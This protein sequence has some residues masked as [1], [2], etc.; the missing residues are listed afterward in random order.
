MDTEQW[1]RIVSSLDYAFQPIVSIHTG[2]SLGYEA[3]LRN[4]NNEGFSGIQE[5][6]DGA[7]EDGMLFQVELWLR[8]KAIRKFT[9]I[10]GHQSMKLFFNIDNRVL[11][12]PDY[13]PGHTSRLLQR[14]GLLPESLCFE[15]SERHELD[16]L[17]N[18][19]NILSIYRQQ[20]YKIAIDD[21]GA[22]YSGLRLLYHSEPDFIKID[23]FFI[24]G[25]E[26]DSKK[27]LFVGK[28]LNLAHILG[29]IVIA[30]GVETEKEYYICK[31]IGC[32][33]IQGYLVQRPTLNVAELNEKYELI[34]GLS[35]KDRRERT[36]DHALLH[37]QM[38]YLEPI[39]L[40]NS[41]NEYFTDMSTVFEKFRKSRNRSFFPVTNG[42]E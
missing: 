16:Y 18:Y 7:Y 3:L 24:A 33:Y 22:G 42:H 20:A 12:M 39:S 17:G 6:F 2:L 4:W 28:V 11:I 37:E 36:L 41:S 30:E 1:S 14:Y 19:D 5:V 10:K 38:D 26:T 34:G 31:E 9:T 23:R 25:I 15:I 21:F 8:E 35:I 32:D 40:H 13:S 29:I 27:K